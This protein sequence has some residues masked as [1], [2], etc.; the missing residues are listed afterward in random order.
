MFTERRIERQQLPYFLN[1]YNRFTDKTVGNLGSVSHDDLMLVSQLPMMI[2]V[3][4]ELRLKIPGNDG[5][6]QFIDFTA[7][8]LWCHEDVTPN[9]YD[10]GFVLQRAP[11]EYHQLVDDVRR[12]FSFH[13]LQ[14][15]A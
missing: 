15:S 12:Y 1:V 2:N 10:A 6:L 14:T 9:Y 13:P 7:R 11:V 5:A 3:D 4:F 8:C